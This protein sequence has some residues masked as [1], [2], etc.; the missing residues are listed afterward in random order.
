MQ[1]NY[2]ESEKRI[3][4]LFLYPTNMAPTHSPFIIVLRPTT[5]AGN[6]YTFVKTSTD[7]SEFERKNKWCQLV[8][9]YQLSL[10][11]LYWRSLVKGLF[12][13]SIGER[14]NL[15]QY[16]P[17]LRFLA[18]KNRFSK[19]PAGDAR[20]TKMAARF[21]PS[22]CFSQLSWKVCTWAK[23]L[24]EPF[25]KSISWATICTLSELCSS[26]GSGVITW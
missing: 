11:I 8:T 3:K 4:H 24:W 13:W 18:K 21:R 9:D 5:I 19:I 26:F 10:V 20:K 25:L 23:K 7:I 15:K 2:A 22:H 12:F 17:K 1:K 16:I 14:Q 6:S